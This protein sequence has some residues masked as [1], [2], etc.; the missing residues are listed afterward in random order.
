[1]VANTVAGS[2][3]TPNTNEMIDDR[4]IP[5]LERLLTVTVASR[6]AFSHAANVVS[7]PNVG[8]LLLRRTADQDRLVGNIR[9]LLALHSVK[10]Q[11]SSSSRSRE[12]DVRQGDGERTD[13]QYE[14]PELVA[15][16]GAPL[17][18]APDSER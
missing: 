11:Q 18:S 13:T 7:S 12:S 9:F 6:D 16:R 4:H 5:M 14:A 10:P 17:A 15:M 8:T 1:M 2:E 3:M